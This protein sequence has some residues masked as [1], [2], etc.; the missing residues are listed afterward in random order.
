MM[1]TYD[2]RLFQ[3]IDSEDIRETRIIL[4]QAIQNVA[5]VGRK[6]LPNKSRD[7]NSKLIWVPA[8][9][10]MA[11]EWI[12]GNTTFRS[13]LCLE[14]FEILLVDRKVNTLASFQLEGKTYSQLMIWLE[15]QIGK[16]GLDASNLTLNLPYKIPYHPVEEGE[17]FT[18]R[19]L[20]PATELS[21]FYHNTYITLRKIKDRYEN[22]DIYI[23]P[24]RF[25][26][27]LEITLKETG[28]YDTNTRI[29]FGMSPGDKIFESPYFYV[30][31]WPNVDT[32][33]CDKLS[34]NAIWMSEEWTGA[35]LLSKHVYEG[36]QQEKLETF[37]KE[38]EEQLI[39]LLME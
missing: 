9:S 25:D 39:R 2:W 36:N 32:E 12:H 26:I 21:K 18:L 13:S 31:T 11:G 8:L 1:D 6:L 14:T 15:E 16:F 22:G 28:D 7:F 35:V 4:H 19:S 5:S 20:R 30:S 24:N 27:T 23:W 33:K 3:K 10:R 17:L 38:A 37:F 29:A 34:H